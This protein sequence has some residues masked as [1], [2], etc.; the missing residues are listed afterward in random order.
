MSD[1]K[2]S[3]V[4]SILNLILRI[5]KCDTKGPRQNKKNDKNKINKK[6]KERNSDLPVK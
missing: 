2:S 3:S 1:W 4:N 5:I 6:R